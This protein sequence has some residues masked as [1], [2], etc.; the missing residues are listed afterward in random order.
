MS[1]MPTVIPQTVEHYFLGAL[2]IQPELFS[3]YSVQCTP[4]LFT[5]T[6]LRDIFRE[7]VKQYAKHRTVSVVAVVNMV[8]G[9]D[10][11]KYMAYETERMQAETMCPSSVLHEHYFKEMEEAYTQR[12]LE[13]I[14]EQTKKMV[15]DGRSSD[16]IAQHVR[17]MQQLT[18]R[19][20]TSK[21]KSIQQVHRE[22]YDEYCARIDKNNSGIQNPK[23]GIER[24]DVATHGVDA[25]QFVVIGAQQGMGKSLFAMNIFLNMAKQGKS[26]L[27]C[28]LEMKGAQV[29][30]RVWSHSL[31]LPHGKLA[32]YSDEESILERLSSAEK[33][34]DGLDVHYFCMGGMTVQD[35][36][37]ELMKKKYDV[38]VVDYVQLMREPGANSYERVSR[39]SNG[40]KA[41]AMNYDCAVIGLSQINKEGQ[42]AG[43][44]KAYHLK[45]SSSLEQDA[46]VIMI[47]WREMD[48][49]QDVVVDDGLH[50]FIEKN[51]NGPSG[52]HV[53]LD[54]DYTHMRIT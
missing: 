18:E 51:R 3:Y 43:R 31:S 6:I 30:T 11:E 40:L 46:E 21:V 33:E 42:K 32:D 16:E 38:V 45:D 13:K 37:K 27:F 7:C 2:C 23:Y 1:T 35:I 22:S 39:I 20:L 5:N 50:V 53:R 4:E 47:L 12:E 44:P 34:F 52:V 25:G 8:W 9:S 15:H 29:Q 26:I 17:T 54:V 10:M 19:S 14:A 48:E 28:S 49:D 41:L 24:I 36:E